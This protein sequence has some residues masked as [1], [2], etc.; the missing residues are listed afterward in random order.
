MDIL[1]ALCRVANSQCLFST[2]NAIKNWFTASDIHMHKKAYRYF[3][4]KI[5]N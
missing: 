2:L 1:T 3:L 5:F 4:L